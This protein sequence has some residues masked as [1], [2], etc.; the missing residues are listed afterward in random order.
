MRCSD[1][2]LVSANVMTMASDEVESIK[3]FNQNAT[4]IK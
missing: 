1:D 2:T 4:T 3:G